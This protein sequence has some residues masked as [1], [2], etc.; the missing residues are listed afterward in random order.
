MEGQCVQHDSRGNLW[1]EDFGQVATKLC[2]EETN[3]GGNLDNEF[4]NWVHIIRLELLGKAK[5]K[6]LSGQFET[7]EPDRTECVHDWIKDVEFWV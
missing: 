7:P 3:A 6:C 2:P 4:L 5:W 1:I